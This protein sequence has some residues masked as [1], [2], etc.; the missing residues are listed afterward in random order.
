MQKRYL[1]DW[2]ATFFSWFGFRTKP[3]CG[4]EMRKQK[5]NT[6]HQSV[7]ARLVRRGK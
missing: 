2:L 3:G 4:C 5:L 6:M 7:E 1:G